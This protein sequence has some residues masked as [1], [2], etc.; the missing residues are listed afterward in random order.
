M[1]TQPLHIT[2]M[3]RNLF[4]TTKHHWYLVN[5]VGELMYSY[6]TGHALLYYSP[7][8][9]NT[10]MRQVVCDTWFPPDNCDN[11]AKYTTLSFHVHIY[12][13][14]YIYIYIHIHIYIH[15]ERER[16]THVYIY[17]YIHISLS[18]HIYIYISRDI[19]S[20]YVYIYTYTCVYI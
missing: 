9:K 13:Y 12:I 3:V 7:C 11:S 20:V 16:D 17:I 10:C 8:L 2:N 15:R 19:R 18:R 1:T 14:M 4:N 5:Q 6:E